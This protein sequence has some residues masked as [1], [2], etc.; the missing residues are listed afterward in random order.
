[1][2]IRH[3]LYGMQGKRRTIMKVQINGRTLTK[4]GLAVIVLAGTIAINTLGY[5]AYKAVEAVSNSVVADVVSTVEVSIAWDTEVS[6]V[7]EA[8]ESVNGEL[9]GPKMKQAINEFHELN[10]TWKYELHQVQAG[11]YQV[12]VIK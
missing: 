3:H 5:T 2:P 4:K 1:M 6:S 8:I 12:P 9:N 11:V 10:N 7:V